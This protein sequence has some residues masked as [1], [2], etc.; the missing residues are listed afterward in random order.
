MIVGSNAELRRLDPSLQRSASAMKSQ[1]LF[2]VVA[3]FAGCSF[4]TV[5]P[6]DETLDRSAPRVEIMSPQR[7]TIAGD[8]THV[9]VTG[10]ASDDSGVVESVTV[11]G[12]PAAL[13]ADGTWSV[14]VAVLPGTT[15]L[16]AIAFDAEDNQGKQTHAIVSGPMVALD[17]RVEHGISGTLSAPALLTLG[18]NTAALIEAGGLM[19]AVDG[20]NPVV[21]VGGGPNCLYGQASIT[22]LTIGDAN[23]LMGPTNGGVMVS[24]VLDDVHVGMHLQWAVACAT[25]SRDVVV[26]AQRVTVQGLLTVG[27]VDRTLDVQFD[28]PNVQVTGF[29]PQLQGVPP[30]AIQLLGLDAAISP[31]LGSMTERIVVPNVARSLSPL[32]DTRTIDVAGTQIDLDI[33]PAQVSFSP[34]GGTIAIDTSLRAHGDQG[35]FVFV[36]NTKPRLDMKHGFEL[37]IADDAANQLLTSMWSAKAFDTT[38]DLQSESYEQIGKL[39]DSVEL[40]LL[41]PPHVHAHARPLE[42]TIGD[43]IA[44]FKHGDVAVTTVAIHAKTALYVTEDDNGKLRMDVSTPAV[45]VDLVGGGNWISKAQ[46]DAIKAFA[47][48]HVAASGHAAIGAVPLPVVGDTMPNLWVEPESNHLLVVGDVQ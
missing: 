42:L 9:L 43:W 47:S 28:E 22:S 44:T 34:Q 3:V 10:T 39:Y 31:I 8:V 46:Y 19:S 5:E 15:L 36:S 48:E 4:E 32:D 30:A 14:E 25:G 18:H 20:I 16:Q 29:D 12:V 33:A 7:G 17:G 21:D 41:V 26:T 23:V 1:P 13:A 37:A 6:D 40:Q 11:N 27:V 38:I 2:A 24:A 35:E 45:R